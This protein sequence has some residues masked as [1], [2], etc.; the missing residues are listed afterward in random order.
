MPL[1]AAV[2]ASLIVGSS[3]PSPRLIQALNSATLTYGSAINRYLVRSRVAEPSA[4]VA[5]TAGGVG[6]D[7]A[8]VPATVT[9]YLEPPANWSSWFKVTAVVLAR[10]TRRS[11]RPMLSTVDVVTRPRKSKALDVG[12]TRS[13]PR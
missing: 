8:V 12:A 5:F 4:T 7:A 11:D 9:V 10:R 1:D 2:S 13:R 3:T 6:S